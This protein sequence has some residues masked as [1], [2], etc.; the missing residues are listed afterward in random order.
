MSQSLRVKFR[1]ITG[2]RLIAETLEG[3]PVMICC[4]D[5]QQQE[6]EGLIIRLQPGALFNL[7]NIT[8]N[9]SGILEAEFLVLEPDYLVDISALAECFRLYGHHPL[10]YSLSRIQPIEN[11]APLLLGNTANFFIDELVHE[12]ETA[13]VDYFS[14]LKKLFKN[15]PFEFT[16]CEELKDS[17]S[18]TEFFASCQKHFQHIR[19]VVSQ[20]FPKA[21]IDRE[22][23]VLEPSFI[24][25]ALGVQGRLDLMLCDFSAFVELKSGKGTEDFRTGGQF[26][27]SSINHYTQMIL[28]LAVLEFNLD[29]QADD[30]RSYLLYSK[31]PVLSKERHSRRHL[32]EAITLRNA[33]VA[34]EY[35]IQRRNNA[36]HTRKILDDIRSGILNTSGLTGTF[37]DRYLQPSIDRFHSAFS[38]LSEE[39]QTYWMRL[40]TFVVKELWLSKVGEREYEGI[41]KASNLWNVSFEDKII[42]GE[43]L[44]DLQMTDNQAA[45]ENHTVTLKIP[46]YT[47][48]YLPN[49]RPGDAVVLYERNSEADTVNNHQVFKGS[50][51]R[52]KS[53]SV[54]I[55]L[56]YRQKNTAVWKDGVLYALE[57]DYMDSTYTGMFRALYAF[58]EANQD[59]RDLL[60][61]R[62]MPE[63]FPEQEGLDSDDDVLRSVR[64]AMAARD[65]FMLVGPP[66]TGKTSLALKQLVEACLRENKTNILLLSYTNR[67]VDEIC[68]ALLSV[69]EYLPFIRIGSELNCAPEYRSH[70]LEHCLESCSRRN[71]VQ[72]VIEHCRIFVGTVASVWN[73]PGLFHLKRFDMAIVDEATQLLEPHLLGIL[74]AK[75]SSGANAV[76]R[77]VLIGDHK[78]LPAVILQSK[79][80]SRVEEPVLQQ[81][82]LSDLSNS[83]FERLYRKYR[84]AGIDAA[85][86]RLSK[87]GRMHP[88]ISSF[89]SRYFYEGKLECA[90]LPHQNESSLLFPGVTDD[91]S[92]RVSA[93]RLVFLNIERLEKEYADKTN[94][95][96]AALVVRICREFYD[97][98]VILGQS[99]DPQTIGI[100]TP[101]RNQIALIRKKLQETGIEA[102]SSIVIDTVERFQGSQKD[103]II[104]SFCVS[105]SRQ[106]AALPNTMEE[107][108]IRIDR[109]LNV[110]LTRARK[111]LFIVGN[112]SLLSENPIYRE[113]IGHIRKEG[114]F[115]DSF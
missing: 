1:E 26:L 29:L 28:Y 45:S 57:H 60:L 61:C 3:K 102:F 85:F 52:L 9:V 18:E 35:D 55:R 13:P 96:E 23:V 109:K 49:F 56:R 101:F 53:E 97:R 77:F 22:K 105:T 74:C 21:G 62:R 86:D 71:E 4:T 88:L 82:G 93:C 58:L 36:G 95:E 90:G 42:A 63:T 2:E 5:L 115:V 107:N 68:K 72:Y 73:K 44:Y 66:G 32:Q 67:A 94:P 111:Q 81:T 40:Y 103:C 113:L 34:L 43:I 108:G 87:Q 69:S 92:S 59:R 20:L 33:I 79:E 7:L 16:A 12:E 110:V 76:S 84:E 38:L 41:A 83:L 98:S 54:T 64:K 50:I 91:F 114:V 27:H 31:Y 78:Q 51:E 24:S 100:I 37:F 19:Q 106:L 47:D 10:N 112:A 104:Y 6:L 11:T 65:C 39:E 89:P 15:S 46:E 70:L 80:E 48:L 8:E 17:R 75:T 99:F 14:V 25:N 30:I